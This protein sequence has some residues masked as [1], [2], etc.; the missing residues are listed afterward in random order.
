LDRKITGHPWVPQG[1]NYRKIPLRV[2][3][4]HFLLNVM[5]ASNASLLSTVK[6]TLWVSQTYLPLSCV[7]LSKIWFSY[8]KLEKK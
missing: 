6:P 7:S 3:S 8:F 4:S 2:C 5:R 1:L